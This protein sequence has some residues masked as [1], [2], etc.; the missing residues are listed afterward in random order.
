MNPEIQ[1][2]ICLND[3]EEGIEL[4]CRHK[5]CVKCLENYVEFNN[6]CPLCKNEFLWY[7]NKGIKIELNKEQLNSIKKYKKS[8]IENEHFDCITKDNIQT[9]LN[10]IKNNADKISLELFGPRN[11]VGNSKESEVLNEIYDSVYDN[12]QKLKE[13]L[14]ENEYIELIKS[15]DNL[16]HLCVYSNSEFVNINLV[17]DLLNSG[18]LAIIWIYTSRHQHRINEY[19][20]GNY[21]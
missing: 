13:E 7:K 10:L 14:E 19:Y 8:E 4:P 11:E 6:I 5:T 17:F 9:Q 20:F 2:P 3:I 21:R 16:N 15:V 1:C 18:Y 12:Q